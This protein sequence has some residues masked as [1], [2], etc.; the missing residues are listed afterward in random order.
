MT[1]SPRRIIILGV[2]GT[3]GQRALQILNDDTV[4][5]QLIAV[6]SHTGT[7]DTQALPFSAKH[8]FKTSNPDDKHAL[9]DLLRGGDYDICLNA[10]VG[11]AGL[12]YSE[13]VIASGKNL[14]LANKESLVMAGSLL[15][16][17]AAKSNAKIIP[18]DSEHSAIFQCLNGDDT[19]VRKLF[20]TASGGALRDT[21]LEQLA[22]TTPAQALDHPNWDMGPRITIDSATMMNKAF[23]LIEAHWLF[24]VSSEQMQ[25]LIHR[26]S[27]IHSM[28]EFVDGS[29]LA[30]LGPPDMGFPLHY[31]LHYPARSQSNLQGFD[32]TL[33]ANLSLEQPDP[34]R[35]PALRLADA[36]ISHGGTAGAVLNAADEEAV[37]AFLD[38]RIQFND[39][40][41]LCDDALASC[42]SK[43]A[44]TM[45]DIFEADQRTRDHC[46]HA[47]KN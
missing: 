3:V 43:L 13:A 16:P 11:A 37:A 36:V 22:S 40:A 29:V 23:E 35:Y 28:V 38:G 1:S 4:D 30:Q 14:A 2:T 26:Q 8:C 9:L 25:V 47:I 45:D 42:S 6:S 32:P 18:V 21:P 24:G 7:L 20:L 33:Y 31:A 34:Q 19:S 39:I 44:T 41:P 17:L 15:L 12:P 10:I 27:V 46:N 5:W